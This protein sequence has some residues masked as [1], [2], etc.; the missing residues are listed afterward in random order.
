MLAASASWLGFGIWMK[1]R[2]TREAIIYSRVEGK[3][4]LWKKNE[5]IIS[6]LFLLLPLFFF[7]FNIFINF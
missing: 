6:F 4:T 3:K 5:L 7:T 2:L 1:K